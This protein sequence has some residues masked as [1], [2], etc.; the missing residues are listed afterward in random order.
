[1]KNL[2]SV[3]TLTSTIL[4]SIPIG[5]YISNIIASKS[6]VVKFKTRFPKKSILA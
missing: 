2:T 3:I 4:L 5:K 6:K 1:M